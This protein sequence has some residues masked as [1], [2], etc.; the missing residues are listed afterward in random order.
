MPTKPK[1]KTK[2][3]TLKQL[4][5][6][7]NEG[8]PDSAMSTYYDEQGTPRLAAGG[9][10]LALFCVI[11]IAETYSPESTDAEKVYEAVRVLSR[12]QEDLEA[13]INR[14]AQHAETV[15]VL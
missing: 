1:T 8:Y 3:L 9:D 5:D 12:A 2:G 4:L 6:I 13:A 10:T 11:E 15:E 7:A 14:L